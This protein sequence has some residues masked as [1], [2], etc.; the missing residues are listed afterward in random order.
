MPFIYLSKIVQYITAFF[1]NISIASHLLP[2]ILFFIFHNRNR[3]WDVRVILFYCLYAFVNDLLITQLR[4]GPTFTF[5]SVFT[6][7][8]Y[9]LCSLAIYLNLNRP[10][11]KKII[12]WASPIFLFFSIF[13]FFNSGTKNDIDNITITV[14]Y[15]FLIIYCLFF[16]FEV[17]NESSTTI[18]YSSHRFWIVIGVL[19]YS[20]GTFFLFM[21]SSN[22]SETAWDRWLVINY[23]FT[24]IKNIFFSV[25]IIIKSSPPEEP[26]NPPFDEI[27]DKPVTP[28]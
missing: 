1:L 26:L 13:Q 3:K 4:S 28:L 9:S 18:I 23:I 25:A 2:I 17:L 7:V 5:L 22:M 16:L 19:I 12:L 20:T 11:F 15:I 27:F 8:E 14:E 24:T 6:V 10:L 21:Q